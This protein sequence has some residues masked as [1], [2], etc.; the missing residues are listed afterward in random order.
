[1]YEITYGNPYGVST[2]AGGDGSRQPSEN[3]LSMALYQGR[4]VAKIAKKLAGK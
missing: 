2:I 4:H 3:E 1:M